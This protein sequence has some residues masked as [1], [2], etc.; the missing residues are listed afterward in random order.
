MKEKD[1]A[2]KMIAPDRNARMLDEPDEI[3]LQYHLN[4]RH[5]NRHSHEEDVRSSGWMQSKKHRPQRH[6]F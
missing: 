6:D 5:H 4:F 2:S 3:E 1:R